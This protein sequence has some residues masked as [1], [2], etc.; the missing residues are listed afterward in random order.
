MTFLQQLGRAIAAN[1]APEFA[2]AAC[3]AYSA[4][5]RWRWFKRRQLRQQLEIAA[6]AH[7]AWATGYDLGCGAAARGPTPARTG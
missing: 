5:P 6:A 1:R 2:L 7:L 3:G 4:C